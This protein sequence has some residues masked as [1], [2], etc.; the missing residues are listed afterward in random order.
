[1]NP[2]LLNQMTCDWIYSRRELYPTLL[3]KSYRGKTYNPNNFPVK[4]G[5]DTAADGVEGAELLE[6]YERGD[7][8]LDSD[9]E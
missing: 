2:D 7:I 6:A 3:H 9:G 4:Y 1:M 8:Q 5:Q